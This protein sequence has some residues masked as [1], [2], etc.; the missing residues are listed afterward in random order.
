MLQSEI[1]TSAQTRLNFLT[2][3]CVHTSPSQGMHYYAERLDVYHS[4]SHLHFLFATYKPWTLESPDLSTFF[5]L[6]LI[7][8]RSVTHLLT[9]IIKHSFPQLVT[10]DYRI[11]RLPCHYEVPWKGLRCV[12]PEC[13]CRQC[14]RW[15]SH[16]HATYRYGYLRAFQQRQ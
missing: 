13:N 5:L 1:G 9:F 6:T 10:A 15:G 11:I 12:T 16:Y 2:R 7:W 8:C 14:T 4:E 3:V